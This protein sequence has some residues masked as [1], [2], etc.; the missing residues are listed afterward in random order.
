MKNTTKDKLPERKAADYEKT[1][2]Y[3]QTHG[4][5]RLA[6]GIR[7]NLKDRKEST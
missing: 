3:F 4:W 1:I 6:E 7:L 5:A 2:A